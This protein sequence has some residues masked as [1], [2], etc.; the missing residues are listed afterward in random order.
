[1]KWDELPD[2]VQ[3]KLE[4]SLLAT[5]RTLD[6]VDFASLLSSCTG[7]GLKWNE[8]NDLRGCFF[9]SFAR[10]FSFGNSSTAKSFVASIYNF[11][12]IG[13]LWSDV[14][15]DVRKTILEG[16]QHQSDLF[17]PQSVSN[18]LLG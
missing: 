14:P 16:I 12:R 9:S 6:D 17:D 1:V 7:L 4:L 11:G 15:L 2:E 13:L 5:S 8:R 18:V 3:S 10:I